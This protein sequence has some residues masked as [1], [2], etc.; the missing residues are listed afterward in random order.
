VDPTSKAHAPGPAL[1]AL[2]KAA[3]QSYEAADIA[4]RHLIDL[5]EHYNT[6]CTAAAVVNDRVTILASTDAGGRVPAVQMGS[7]YRFAPPIGLM[8]ATWDDPAAFD[9]W[10]AR[11][12]T[13][14]AQLD[15]E[16][17]R[18]IAAEAR[19]RG[20]LIE[21]LTSAGHRLHTLT[22]GFAQYQLPNE[23]RELVGQLVADLG[24]RTYLTGTPSPREQHGVSLLAA[25]TFN[26]EG[27]QELVLSMYVG[28]AVT[29][30]EI[31]RRGA[32]LVAVAH[33][34]TAEVGG[35]LPDARTRRKVRA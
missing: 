24:D 3:R 31:A 25:P 13:I 22:S 35:T 23:V 26:A 20:Y 9:A 15:V 16:Q 28:H 30:A 29:G 34:V 10:I 27:R 11:P 7:S 21:G 19:G 6:A 4:E 33:T 18:A 12:A 14:P 5:S 32:A 17:L 1:I 8:F 2:G